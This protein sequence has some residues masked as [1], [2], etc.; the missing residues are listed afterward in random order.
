MPSVYEELKI[1]FYN[2]AFWYHIYYK[3]TKIHKAELK[4][5]QERVLKRRKELINK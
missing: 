4:A 5:V 3:H 1:R 2:S